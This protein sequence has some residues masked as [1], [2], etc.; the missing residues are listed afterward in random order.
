MYRFF[1]AIGVCCLL[2]ALYLAVLTRTETV[3]QGPQPPPPA[4]VT[5]ITREHPANWG[6][7]EGFAMAGGLCF[8]AAAL[9]MHRPRESNPA[10][11]PSGERALHDFDQHV[12]RL[13]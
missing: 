10:M 4:A 5:R 12:Q 1:S 2:V 6:A 11:I 7:A 8:I 3:Y 13:R 9:A